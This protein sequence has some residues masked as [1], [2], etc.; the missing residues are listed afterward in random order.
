MQRT[1]EAV[2][3]LQAANNTAAYYYA[4]QAGTLSTQQIVTNNNQRQNV[5][6]VQNGTSDQQMLD[7]LLRALYTGG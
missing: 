5:T 1:D 7:R 6:L 2:A 4:Q 3:R